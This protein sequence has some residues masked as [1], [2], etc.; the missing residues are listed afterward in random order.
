MCVVVGRY[1]ST[2]DEYCIASTTLTL[3]HTLLLVKVKSSCDA[4]GCV[5]VSGDPSPPR[6]LLRPKVKR[7][8]WRWCSAARAPRSGR[9][10]DIDM[11]GWWHVA[12]GSR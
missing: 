11:S 2:V 1:A 4:S 6:H 9:R 12:V 3:V 7:R 8:S 10:E 5:D